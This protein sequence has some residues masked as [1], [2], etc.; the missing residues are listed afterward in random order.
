METIRTPD[1]RFANLPGYPFAPKYFESEGLRIH[2]VDEGRAGSS[3]SQKSASPDDVTFLCLH[4]E[5][6]WSYLYRKMIPLLAKR[7]RVLAPDLAGFGKSDKPTNIEDYTFRLHFD[8]L[9]D[10]LKH[11][12]AK[13]IVLVCQDWGGLLGLPLAMELE[14][15]FTGIVIMNTGIPD[16]TSINWLQPKNIV[17]GIGFMAWRTFAVNHPD[18]PVGQV[19]SAGCWPPLALDAD[20]RAAYDAPFPEKS[21]KAGADAFPRLV[22]IN[23]NHATLPY[24]QKARAKIQQSETRKLILFSNRDPI[25]WSQRE[26]F[27]NLKNVVADVQIQ[28]AGHFLQ[29]DK[30][31]ELAENILRYF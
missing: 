31:E 19:V 1:S 27:T 26:Y 29:E 17:G 13:N 11:T 15:I 30:G 8:I 14:S 9:V 21:Y 5:P 6:T 2:Y 22:P 12:K 25:T 4:G 10:F 20:I 24:M 3:A 28:N 7:G 18:L 16:P 23:A